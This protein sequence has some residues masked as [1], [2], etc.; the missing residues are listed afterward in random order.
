MEALGV[1][2]EVKSFPGFDVIFSA[3]Q[4]YK[5]QHGDVKVPV[6]FIVPKNDVNYPENTWGMKLG[7]ALNNI[8]SR[9]GYSEHKKQLEALGVTSK[10]WIE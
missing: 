7:I 9:G 6:K 4:S 2:F 3:L 1:N 10:K 8:R 5:A